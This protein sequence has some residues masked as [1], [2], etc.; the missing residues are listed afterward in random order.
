VGEL[1][2]DISRDVKT[3]A[4]DDMELARGRLASY[5]EHLMMKAG[6]AVIGACVA[7]IG[8]GLLCLAVV[9]AIE[10]IIH[11]LWLR[12]FVM[13]IFYLA[14]GG[15]MAAVFAKRLADTPR[16]HLLEH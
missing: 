3:I 5:L 13:A 6:G 16:P 10:P 2:A 12:L 1:L 9:A 15:T 11:P 8:L 4:T 7:L 14:V